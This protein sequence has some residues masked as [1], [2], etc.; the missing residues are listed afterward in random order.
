MVRRGDGRI[1]LGFGVEL[2]GRFFFARRRLE[3]GGRRDLGFGLEGEVSVFLRLVG[4]E[5]FFTVLSYTFFCFSFIVYGDY[6]YGVV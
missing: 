2:L 6:F 5:R 1:V 4:L 3:I